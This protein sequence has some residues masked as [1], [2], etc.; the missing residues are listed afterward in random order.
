MTLFLLQKTLYSQITQGPQ[1][2]LL[3]LDGP[4]GPSLASSFHPLGLRLNV[5]SG[6][7]FPLMISP[8]TGL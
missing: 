3:Y 2:L 6:G 1:K 7:K 8:Q 4:P 5:Y